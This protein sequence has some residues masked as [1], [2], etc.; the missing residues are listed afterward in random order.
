MAGPKKTKRKIRPESAHFVTHLP[1]EVCVERLRKMGHQ[2]RVDLD[3][4]TSDR[5]D[6]LA[7]LY[8][9]GR[10][11]VTARGHLSRWEGTLTRV[12]CAAYEHDGILTWLLIVT[13]FL[14]L[15]LLV[16]PFLILRWYGFGATMWVLL[17]AA[18]VVGVL[19]WTRFVNRFAPADDVPADLIGWIED[20]LR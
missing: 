2:V 15:F 17:S 13:A 19:L 1:I 9:H 6:F 16:I 5:V 7:R 10:L 18:L 11:R 12:D 8:E 4:V 20:A 14:A 3:H